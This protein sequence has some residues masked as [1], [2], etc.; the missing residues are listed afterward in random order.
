MQA[1]A[2]GRD[3]A[4]A[5]IDQPALTAGRWVAPGRAVIERGFADAL[6]LGV[7]DTIRLGGRPFRVAGI[8]VSTAQCFY[9]V[10][11]PGLIWLTRRRGLARHPGSSRSATC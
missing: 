3:A 9:P 7:G 2:E 4:P 1:E 11:T 8:A 6:G 10:S 5:A